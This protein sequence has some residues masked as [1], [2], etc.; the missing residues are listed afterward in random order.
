MIFRSGLMY[1]YL[2]VLIFF[3]INYFVY[4]FPVVEYKWNKSVNF[5]LNIYTQSHF[6]NVLL[7]VCTSTLL[8]CMWPEEE[9]LRA[10]HLHILQLCKCTTHSYSDNNSQGILL[11]CTVFGLMAV[12]VIAFSIK[13][14][15][16]LA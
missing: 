6:H 2:L 9:P 12:L 8:W 11:F 4:I 7:I 13:A 14:S 3:L 5:T 1:E 10:L 16:N 15:F